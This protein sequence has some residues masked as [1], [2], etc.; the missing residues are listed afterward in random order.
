VGENRFHDVHVVRDA[1]LVRDRQKESVR[2]GDGFVLPELFDE[3]IG[4]RGVTP[5]EHRARGGIEK[6]DLVR[7]LLGTWHNN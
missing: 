3:H 2:P 1:E 5:T 7:R 4:F 6:S